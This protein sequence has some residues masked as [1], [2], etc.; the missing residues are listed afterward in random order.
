M[1]T[2]K[3]EQSLYYHR[4]I[5]TFGQESFDGFLSEDLEFFFS[6]INGCW[7]M[8]FNE[9]LG[10]NNDTVRNSKIPRKLIKAKK[11]PN[12]EMNNRLMFWMDNNE[13]VRLIDLIRNWI[14]VTIVAKNH[15]F[16]I[17]TFRRFVRQHKFGPY[18]K[19]LEGDLAIHKKVLIDIK[20]KYQEL[21][22]RYLTGYSP[23]RDNIISMRTFACRLDVAG[24]CLRPNLRRKEIDFESDG[25]A[26]LVTENAFMK[27]VRGV[28]DG[29]YE[30]SPKVAISCYKILKLSPYKRAILFAKRN[31]T[32]KSHSDKNP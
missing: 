16:Q 15:G 30:A 5:S 10:L 17:K 25:T 14:K 23:P 3:A 11:R 7:V 24:H 21:A 22:S 27:F 18:Q 32:K 1:K 19:D 9:Y 6:C 28:V 29:K 20:N 4:L 2:K 12:S 26:F 13:I 31:K 8:D